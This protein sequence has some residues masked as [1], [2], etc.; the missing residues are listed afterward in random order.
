MDLGISKCAVT[1]C[2]NKSKLHPTTFKALIQATNINYRNQPIPA[3]N[4]HEPYTYLGINLAPS[5]KWKT[6]I[7]TT[8]AKVIK[9]CQALLACPATMKQ[10]INM[11]DTV[12]RAGIAYNFYAVPY[13]IPAIK[14]LDKKIIALHKTI[15]GIPKCTSNIATQL[16]HN[17][18][19]IETFSLQNAYLRCIG[20][21]LQNALNDKGR[22]GKIYAGLLQF[23]L[24]K[25][26]GSQEIT[27]IKYHH[28][29]RSPITR[30]LFLFK[31][32]AGVYLKSTINNFFLTPS[33]LETAWMQEA[34]M[35]HSLNPSIS[36]KF[37]HKLLVHN[38]TTL[39]QITMPNGTTLMNPDEFKIYHSTPS[40]LIQSALNI[41]NQQFCQPPC[42]QCPIPC[43]SYLPPRSLK[44]KYILTNH[45]I[46]PQPVIPP[47]HPPHR[48]IP[49]LP[50]LPK[51]CSK[52]LVN[53]PYITYSITNKSNPSVITESKE[54]SRHTYA[55]GPHRLTM[56]IT[57]GERKGTFSPTVKP[58]Y[59]TTTQIY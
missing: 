14:K 9:Q 36:L 27:R 11:A 56:Y 57:N 2:P 44:D 35:L 50:P 16:P 6:Q 5:L 1:G 34:H 23:I 40:K 17:L 45:N 26:G 22:L 48:R 51:T 37:L 19:E 12:I 13:S 43:P 29:V 15:C 4:Q 52:T 47:V 8:T 54:Q 31:H 46:L 55:N 10:K 33:P 25:Y 20:E 42:T 53:Y 41:A 32:K 58:I 59:A 30:T 18:F 28:C 38:I 7:N 3:L 49:P 39:Y 21:Q 24:A